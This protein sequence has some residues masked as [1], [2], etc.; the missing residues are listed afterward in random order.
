MDVLIVVALIKTVAC[1]QSLIMP[2][3]QLDASTNGNTPFFVILAIAITV[4]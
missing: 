2:D 4:P 1:R 3:K